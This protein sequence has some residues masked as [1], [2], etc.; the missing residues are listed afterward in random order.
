MNEQRARWFETLFS[1]APANHDAAEAGIRAYY[2]AAEIE[3]PRRIV[4]LDSPAEACNA[5]LLFCARHDGFMR[6]IADALEKV[7]GPRGELVRVREKVSQVLGI[8]DWTKA[9][10]IMGPPLEGSGA[11]ARHSVRGKITLARISLWQDPSAAMG[12]LAADELFLAEGRFWTVVIHTLQTQGT[13]LERSISRIYHLAWMAMD[14]VRVGDARVPSLLAALW[15]VAR[16]AGPWWPFLNGAVITERPL[17]IHHNGS[18][19]LE[20]GDGPALSYRDGC[21]VFAWDGHSFPEKWIM[22][23]ESIP[24]SKLKQAGASFRA[25]LATR[26]ITPASTK[27]LSLKPSSLLK[28][29]L[30]SDGDLRIEF[31]RQHANGKLPLYDRYQNGEREQVWGELVKLGAAARI[32]PHAADAL[33]VAL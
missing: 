8:G 5:V 27:K 33:A 3:P 11:P 21:K 9:D 30:P 6:R 15:Q 17:E 26:G 16:S 24:A 25:Y 22:Q 19:L 14:E 18:W 20:R 2:Q 10:A 12:K 4:W 31:L 13:M 32:D 1:A 28:I 29:D 7:P 23:P